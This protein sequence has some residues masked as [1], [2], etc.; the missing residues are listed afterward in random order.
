M[1]KRARMQKQDLGPEKPEGLA[2]VDPGEFQRLIG[3]INRQK[4]HASEYAGAAG[5][6]TREAI[7]KHALDR[8][9]FSFVVQLSKMDEAKRQGVIRALIDYVERGG[10]LDQVDAFNDLTSQLK[11]LVDRLEGRIP[12]RPRDEGFESLIQ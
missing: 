12:N 9:A 3:E 1:A 5:K 7:D 2:S 11:A 6:L 4:G 8:K 10:M